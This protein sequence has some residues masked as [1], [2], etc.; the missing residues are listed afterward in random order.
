MREFIAFSW[1]LERLNIS[2]AMAIAEQVAD[3]VGNALSAYDDAISVP[4]VGFFLEVEHSVKNA[5]AIATAFNKAMTARFATGYGMD[6][7]IVE[8]GGGAHNSETI[9]VVYGNANVT[10]K[11]FN[12]RDE[13]DRVIREEEEKAERLKEAHDGKIKGMGLRNRNPGM[14]TQKM[15]ESQSGVNIFSNKSQFMFDQHKYDW[16]RNGAWVSVEPLNGGD[17]IQIAAAHAPG[18]DI[19]DKTELIVNAIK[20]QARVQGADILIGD[21]NYRG[22]LADDY[23]EDISVRWNTGTSIKKSNI[24]AMSSKKWDRIMVRSD[25]GYKIESRDP[26]HGGFVS[27]TDNVGTADNPVFA[28]WYR[29]LSDHGLIIAKFTK[30]V[31]QLNLIIQQMNARGGFGGTQGMNLFGVKK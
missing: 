19:T 24:F 17:T 5:T 14:L 26:I 16:Y 22:A 23:F 31:N 28:N 21:F 13:M 20:S 11:T 27:V 4:F 25:M 15:A 12:I 1:N 9:I 2:K 7:Q 29:R 18:P 3:V 6:M 30:Q 10:V 8:C